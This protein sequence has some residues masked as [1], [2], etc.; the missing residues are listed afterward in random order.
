V[1]HLEIHELAVTELSGAAAVLGR[2]MR[3]NPLHVRVFGEDP[4]RREASLEKFFLP[5]LRGMARKG[6]VLGGYRG[7]ALV[8]VCAMVR[9][10]RCQPSMA[11]KMKLA[12]GLIAREGRSTLHRVLEWTGAWSKHDPS[13]AHWHLGP[14]AVDRVAQGQG[15]GSALLEAFSRRMDERRATAYLETDREANVRLYERLG[16]TVV[17]EEAVLGVPNWYMMRTPLSAAR[18]RGT[19]AEEKPVVR[20]MLETALYCD[21]LEGTTRFY[22]E[23]LGLAPL[24]AD[25]RLTALDAGHGSVLLLFRRGGST[26]PMPFPGGIIPPH[27]GAGPVHIAFAVGAADLEAWERRLTDAGI[28]IDGRVHWERGGRSVYFRDPEGHSVE[29]ATPGTWPTY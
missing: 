10:G 17:S 3:D 15:I 8:G 22:R 24:F 28:A 23:F 1:P 12:P 13:E 26:A 6:I 19:V 16:F 11:E 9:P 21:D 29:L 5:V 14:V 27:D 2:G 20:H 25:A 18:S 7:D 4:A